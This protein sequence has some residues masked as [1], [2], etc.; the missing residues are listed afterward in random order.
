LSSAL[1]LKVAQIPTIVIKVIRV[2]TYNDAVGIYF[3]A[4]AADAPATPLLKLVDEA[5]LSAVDGVADE[6]ELSAVDGVA[7]VVGVDDVHIPPTP[8]NALDPIPQVSP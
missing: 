5:E 8:A 7:D 1:R 3:P 6:A 2:T 4:P